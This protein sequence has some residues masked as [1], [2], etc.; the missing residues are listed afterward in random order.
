MVCVA[1]LVTLVVSAQPAGFTTDI[2]LWKSCKFGYNSYV[3]NKLP[4]IASPFRQQS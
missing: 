3:H 4:G 2:E 1:K